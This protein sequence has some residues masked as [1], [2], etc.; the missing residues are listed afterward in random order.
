MELN[1]LLFFSFAIFAVLVYYRLRHRLQSVWLLIASY[2]FYLSWSWWYPVLLASFTLA[3]FWLARRVPKQRRWLWL[4]IC[5]NVLVLAVFKYEQFFVPDLRAA[6]D[7]WG[8]E[9]GSGGL[10]ILLPIGMSFYVVG[11]IAYLVDIY[12]EQATVPT[13]LVNFALFLAYFPKLLAGPIERGRAFMAQLEQP[14]VLDQAAI[15]RSFVLILLGVVRKAVIGNTLFMTFPDDLWRQ[16]A[17]YSAF[18]LCSYSLFYGFAL[19]NDFAGYSMIAR[20]VSGFFGITLSVNFKTPYFSRSFS[21]FWNRWHITFSHWLRDYIFYP[22]SRALLRRNPSR[23]NIPN[24]I[25]PPIVTM[26]VSG[27]WHGTGWAML[28]WGALHGFYLVGERILLW[29]WPAGPVTRQPI[30]RQCLSMFIVFAL[31]TFAWVPFQA[32][33]VAATVEYWKGMLTWWDFFMPPKQIFLVFIFLLP[34]LWL[35][36]VQ[37]H[38]E[39]ELVLLTWSPVAKAALLAIA[40]LVTF[41]FT[42]SEPGTPFV[43]QGF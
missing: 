32:P 12:R 17:E 25:F 16:P 9:T 30:W 20:G 15:E 3:N 31:V 6:L 33:S 29:K 35:D 42:L 38:S 7:S 23:N 1:S 21:E 8:I 34:A 18:Q 13:D 37:N 22:I 26:L 39:D 11:M 5:L 28:L 4:G 36:W 14:R 43:Y 41:V 19:Y 24:I 40:L 10:E 2:L 27:L